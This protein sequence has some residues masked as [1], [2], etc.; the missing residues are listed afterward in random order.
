MMNLELMFRAHLVSSNRTFYDLAVSHANKTIANHL[1]KDFSSWHVVSFNETTGAVVRKFTAQGYSDDS[2]WSR[3]QAWLVYGFTTTY[4]YT[5]MKHFLEAAKHVADYYVDN[6]PE[7]GVPFWDFNVPQSKYPY[8]P[9]D[10][11]SAAIAASGL[12]QLYSHSNDTKYL[13]AAHK[14]MNSLS[15][16]KY[17]ADGKPEYKIPALIVNTTITGPNASPGKYDLALSYA[18]YYY[19]KAFQYYQ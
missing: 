19:I 2:C 12:F 13:S 5:K 11:S 10:S 16:A 15:S 4:G 1:R 6:L 9:R 7:D 18:D 8:I 3:G 14:I 17:R